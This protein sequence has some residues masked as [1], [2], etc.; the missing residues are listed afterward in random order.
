MDSH[1]E[2]ILERLRG[3]TEQTGAVVWFEIPDTVDES[4]VMTLINENNRIVLLHVD[5]TEKLPV[6]K[7]YKLTKTVYD[8]LTERNYPMDTIDQKKNKHIQVIDALNW[9]ISDN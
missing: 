8:F 9:V 3:L 4:V 6:I 5:Y 2:V 7:A 1:F